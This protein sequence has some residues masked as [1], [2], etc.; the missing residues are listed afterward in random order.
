MD[1]CVLNPFFYPYAGGTERVLYE[2]YKRLAKRNN[3]TVISA[4]LDK[5]GRESVDEISGI[6]VVRLKTKYVDFP[7]F[8]MPFPIMLGLDGA[9]KR[10]YSDIY[11]V[12]NRYIYFYNTISIIKRIG[13]KL[14]LTLHD[15]LP[16][17]IDPLTDNSGY[18]YDVVWGRK[19]IEYADVVTAVSQNTA[20]TTV[21]AKYRKYVRVIY[22]GVDT[23]KFRS[24]EKGESGVRDAARRLGFTKGAINVL[25][26]GRL[27][28]QKGQ[29]YLIRAV[30][31]A[32][33]DGYDINL[34]MIGR[35]YLNDTFGYMAKDIGIQDRMRIVSG[36]NEGDLPYY[37]NAAD[38][39]VSASLYE[40]ASLAV[41]ESL[42]SATP[43]VATKVGGVPEMMH[44][45]GLYVKPGSVS[46]IKKGIESVAD[47]TDAAARR[48]SEGVELMKREHDWN[49]IA[50][51]Y[52][53]AFESVLKS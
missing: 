35:G 11:H 36:I 29:V 12:N 46:A 31:E 30:A 13:R 3:V 22:N 8:P 10:E 38:M 27:V 39:F 43:V 14:A 52:E 47:N 4:S 9:V 37:Y 1:I 2:V 44:R 6:K 5:K 19:I 26:N 20:D 16:K 50:G 23:T 53:N 41:M 32:I 24:R 15:A 7:G 42:A 18:I 28:A 21:P 40:P 17:N 51:Q 48:A 49:V 33:K 34:A 25:N 45:F